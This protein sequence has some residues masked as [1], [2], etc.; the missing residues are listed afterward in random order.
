MDMKE[1]R[2][3]PAVNWSTL[4]YIDDSPEAYLKALST[5]ITETAAMMRGTGVHERF[6]DQPLS[7]PFPYLGPSRTTVE[8]KAA[9]AEWLTE[10]GLDPE[11]RVKDVVTLT[12]EQMVEIDAMV[13]AMQAYAP[14]QPYLD[15]AVFEQK[16]LFEINGVQCKGICDWANQPLETVID[17]KTVRSLYP[18]EHDKQGYACQVA[19][20]YARGLPFV[21][22]RIGIL[23][24]AYDKQ[25][26]LAECRLDW[27]P[28]AVVRWGQDKVDDLL[29]L[30]AVCIASGEYPPRF[31]EATEMSLRCLQ[32][33]PTP[34]APQINDIMAR[35][36]NG[37][38]L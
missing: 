16:M 18:R 32:D 10:R 17:I 6:M 1:Y 26:G 34:Y 22:K 14:V 5:T 28:P 23:L 13:K 33:Q 15:G 7:V 21:P 2:A 31:P 4:R 3:H 27:M 25:L 37:E 30:R 19:G 29:S 35:I 11:S 12:A 38:T 8:G 24:V 36:A 9:W 20:M